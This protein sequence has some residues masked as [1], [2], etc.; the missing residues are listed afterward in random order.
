MVLGVPFQVIMARA[1][2]RG[3]MLQ[4]L[5]LATVL[6]LLL[7][8]VNFYLILSWL[9]RLLFHGDW[10]TDPA[11]LPPWV[12]AATH[13]VFAWT[14]VLLSPWGQYEPYRRQTESAQPEASE[15]DP[16]ASS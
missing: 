4:R 6:G 13:V 12:G 9:Q 7:W 15:E 16:S 11:Y 3:T 1:L 2:P 10:I 5:C 14:M 8:A